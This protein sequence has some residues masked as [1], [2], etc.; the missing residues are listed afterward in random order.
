MRK[1]IVWATLPSGARLR[2]GEMVSVSWDRKPQGPTGAFRYDPAFLRH[3]QS[4]PLDPVTLPLS[5]G[6]FETERREGLHAVFEDALPDSWGRGLLVREARLPRAEQHPVALLPVLGTRGIGALSFS[7]PGTS[8]EPPAPGTAASLS[9]LAEAAE[10]FD[11]GDSGEEGRWTPLFAAGGSAGGARPK[12]LVEEG[13]RKF[14][15]KLARTSDTL[16]FVRTEEAVARLARRCGLP[17]PLTRVADL[18][19]RRAFLVERFDITAQDGRHHQVSLQTLLGAEGFYQAGYED[20]ARVLR[21]YGA[22]PAADLA[23]LYRQMVFNAMMGNTDDHLKNF[24]LHWRADEGFR[25]TPPFDLL[26]DMDGRREHTLRFGSDG[27]LPSRGG[28]LA[29]GRVFGVQ[30]E[31]LRIVREVRTG[32]AGWETV[33]GQCGVPKSDIARLAPGLL[34]RQQSFADPEDLDLENRLSL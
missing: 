9:A 25:L 5:G 18:G 29:L 7:V 23:L 26:P 2:C 34:R 10:A 4:F 19:T 24:A 30:R 21:R 32:C 11:R 3:A 16:D 17:V 12:V 28:L 27:L 33:F 13:G 14:I 6:E 15:A 22:R 20:L 8:P 1:I 31:A